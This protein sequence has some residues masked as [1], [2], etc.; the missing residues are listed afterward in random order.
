MSRLALVSTSVARLPWRLVI[1]FSLVILLCS[2][3]NLRSDSPVPL[4]QKPARPEAEKGPTKISY[5]LYIGDITRIDSADQTFQINF[6]LLLRWH[7]PRLVSS[8]PD[9]REF[10]LGD[11]WN[12]PVLFANQTK[13]IVHS[14]PE[15]VTVSPDGTVVYRQRFIGQFSQSLDLRAFPFDQGVFQIHVIAPG[16]REG[17]ISFVPDASSVW[18]GLKNGVGINENLTLQ[19]WRVGTVMSH[20]EPYIITPGLQIAGCKFEFTA[21]RNSTYFIIKVILPL[22]LIV[23]MSWAV[24]W[25]DP[26]DSGAQFSIAVTAM[27]TLIAYR[28]AIDANV[29]KLPYLTCLD[30]FVL[31]SSLLVFLTLIQ[32]IITSKL[33]KRGDLELARVIDRHCRW[34]FPLAFLLVVVTSLLF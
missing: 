30:K 17:E 14:L 4:P 3:G 1:F 18:L 25:I 31:F 27:L 5:A 21:A 6:V 32:A 10:A 15:I 23:M 7:D 2:G 20:P 22:L 16:C 26:S 28:F 8:S 33:T 11:V 29:P 19:D 9:S 24:F 12:P 34:V 13:D